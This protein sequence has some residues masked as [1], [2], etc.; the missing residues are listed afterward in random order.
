MSSLA[1]TKADGFYRGTDYDPQR[2]GGLNQFRKVKGVPSNAKSRKAPPGASICRFE[3]PFKIWCLGCNQIIDKGVRFN[4]ERRTVGKYFST[5]IL[6][7]AFGCTHCK[8]WLKIRTDPKEAQYRCFEGCRKRIEDYEPNMNETIELKS[9]EE[10]ARMASDPMFSM[11]VKQTAEEK[12]SVAEKRINDLYDLNDR[13]MDYQAVN[14]SLRNGLRARKD[15]VK[16]LALENTTTTVVSLDSC[17]ELDESDKIQLQCV[18]FKNVGKKGLKIQEKFIRENGIKKNSYSREKDL[19]AKAAKLGVVTGL[20][21][22][23]LQRSV[24]RRKS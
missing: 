7:F 14:M 13:H 5:K 18:R 12:T 19:M 11:E 9:S 6:E 15:V 2:D 21:R 22:K 17:I 10:K 1:A 24:L 8:H 4:A 16:Q 20:D 3:M 23:Y